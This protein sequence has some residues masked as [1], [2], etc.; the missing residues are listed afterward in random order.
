MKDTEL[1]TL[2]EKFRNLPGENEWLEFKEARTSFTFDKLGQYFSALSNEANL[3]G[4]E[5]GWLI[6]G[7]RD[8]DKAIVGT[9]FR[10][11]GTSLDRLKGEISSHTT[12]RIGFREIYELS[13]PEGRVLMF[14]IPKAVRGIPTD[15]KGF[16]YGREGDDTGALSQEKR[17]RIRNQNVESDWSAGI[18]VSATIS[19]LDEMAILKARENYKLKFPS[20]SDEVD[21]W[22]DEVFLNKAKITIKGAITR[23]AIILLGKEQSEHFVSPAD[24]KIRWVLKDSKGNEIDWTVESCPFLLAVDRIYSRIR[25]VR[26]RY[27]KSDTLFPDEV[28]RYEPFTIREALNNC[29]AHQDYELRGRINVVEGEDYLVFT[30]LGEFIPESVEKV[31]SDDAPEE[32]YR[33]SF[34]ANAMVSL[35]MVDTIGSGIRKM[36]NFQRQRFFPL[37]EYDLSNQRVK[38]T[39][40]GKVLDIDFAN[41]LARDPGLELYEIVLLDKVQK[42]KPLTK[43]EAAHLR[44]K[45]LIEGIKPN[46]YISA[47]VAQRIEQKA[48]YTR[49]KAF[50]K[51]K[52]FDYI[53]NL[54]EQHSE[55][56]RSNINDLLWDMLPNWMSD[57]QKKT[58]INHLLTELSSKQKIENIGT[59]RHSRWV[60]YN[61]NR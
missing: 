36:F 30:N 9:E 39:V 2:L 46:Y 60:L 15:F 10:R 11:N 52:C 7:I 5:Y 13:L 25:N 27:I 58:R 32:R 17:D 6:F 50:E 20:K 26:Y 57:K 16:C 55:A 18:C 40:I 61:K 53:V 29:I 59:T 28:D 24:V 35:N 37:P 3:K 54:L 12:S 44:K 14:Q 42:K 56:T 34:L 31:I 23:A 8:S 51:Q 19:D 33:N 48:D 22:S 1:K 41:V 43:E 38:V 49:A 4:Q 45:N 21:T 47:R